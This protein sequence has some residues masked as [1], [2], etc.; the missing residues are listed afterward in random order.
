MIRLL[1]IW[2]FRAWPV[3][4]SL[5]VVCMHWFCLLKFPADT[6][7]VNKFTSTILQVV[8][9]FVVLQSVDANLGIFRDLSLVG[10]VVNWFRE[11]PFYNK[12]VIIEVSIVESANISDACGA[13]YIPPATTIEARLERVENRIEKISEQLK[14]QNQ[15]FISFLNETTSSLEQKI[16]SNDSALNKLTKKIEMSTVG[17]FKQQSFGIMLVLYGAIISAFY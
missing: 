9:G 1:T 12:P 8:G 2:I 11:C 15:K 7:L 16:V 6:L 3:L 5:L 17:G 10:V 13:T 4:S 14:I